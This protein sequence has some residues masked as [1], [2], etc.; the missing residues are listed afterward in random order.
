[1]RYCD[2]TVSPFNVE[3]RILIGESIPILLKEWDERFEPRHSI[4][5]ES[6]NIAD[7]LVLKVEE[8][9]TSYYGML[10]IENTRPG[11]II[12]EIFHMVMKIANDKGAIWSEESDEWY[13]YCIQDVYEKIMN[14]YN[15]PDTCKV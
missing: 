3:L 15:N 8:D 9:G 6:Y 12:H 2:I 11:I 14:V 13:A 7:G 5:P 10:L 4:K 1:M